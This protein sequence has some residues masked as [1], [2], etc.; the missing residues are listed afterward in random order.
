MSLHMMGKEADN[1]FTPITNLSKVA[2]SAQE[3]TVN[4]CSNTNDTETSGAIV[5]SHDP[6]EH[7]AFGFKAR[8]I[9]VIANLVHKNKMCQ[10]LVSNMKNFTHTHTQTHKRGKQNL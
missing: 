5:A 9:Q 6:Q 1:Y 2:P 4:M 3:R 8:L 7:P 10:D